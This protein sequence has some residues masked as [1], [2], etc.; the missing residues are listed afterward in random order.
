V[1]ALLRTPQ[2]QL[3]HLDFDEPADVERSA[4]AQVAWVLEDYE[5]RRDALWDIRPLSGNDELRALLPQLH[6]FPETLAAALNALRFYAVASGTA[7]EVEKLAGHADPRVRLAAIGAL[8]SMAVFPTAPTLERCLARNE[9]AER[10]EAANALAKFGTDEALR[11]LSTAAAA[12]PGLK[13]ALARARDRAAAAKSGDL[14]NLV[15]PTLD[16]EDYEDLCIFSPF[17]APQLAAVLRIADASEVLRQRA[18]R[19][20]GLT[21]QQEAGPAALVAFREPTASLSF[22]K[23]LA[24]TLGRVRHYPALPDLYQALPAA[25]P[26]LELVLLEAI[27]KIRSPSSLGV[28]LNHLEG[29]RVPEVVAATRSAL[30]RISRD[31]NVDEEQWYPVGEVP[32][33][34]RTWVYVMDEDGYVETENPGPLL[35]SLLVSR[36][37]VRRRHATFALGQLPLTTER[38]QLLHER[39]QLDADDTVR[40]VAA[41]YLARR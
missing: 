1:L 7:F 29:H 24:W 35:E 33:H 25:D 12:D 27:G 5:A 40:L 17:C 36:S 41:R 10:L 19:V 31:V 23:T 22:R 20:L 37:D 6:P 4:K 13:P 11:A 9:R 34:E 26:E 39:S 38:V 14:N 18:A 28:L 21:R 30:W 2:G 16:T 3:Y 8:G 32:E 15:V